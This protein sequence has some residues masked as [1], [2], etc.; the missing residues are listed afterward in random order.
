M[1]VF[2]FIIFVY[3]F[4]L[5]SIFFQNIIAYT[6][7]T[8]YIT[9]VYSVVPDII[10]IYHRTYIS[11]EINILIYLYSLLIINNNNSVIDNNN[12]SLPR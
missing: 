9:I 1:F 3:V 5:Y 6:H 2:L 12:D 7:I 8:R 10:Y 11:A 4:F